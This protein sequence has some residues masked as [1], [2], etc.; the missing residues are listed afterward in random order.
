MSADHS[1]IGRPDQQPDDG[2]LE[3]VTYHRARYFEFVEDLTKKYPDEWFAIAIEHEDEET[4]M[5][6]G[7]VLGHEWS[8]G[9][10]LWPMREYRKKHPNTVIAF[11]RT[12]TGRLIWP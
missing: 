7:R 6:T 11:F 8:S 4:G 10:L 9:M 12:N 5:V 3:I 2:E 1:R